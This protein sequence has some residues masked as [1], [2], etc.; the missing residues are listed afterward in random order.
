M[1]GEIAERYDLLNRLLSAGVDQ[2]WRRRTVRLVPPSG[3]GPILDVCTGTGDLALAY[4]RAGRKRIAVVGVDFTRPMLTVGQQ[5]LHQAGASK[6]VR[7]VEGD[8]QQ[9]PFG[10]DTFEIVCAAFGLRNVSDTDQGLREMVRVCRP[11][12]RVAVLEFAMPRMWPLRSLYAWYFRHVLPRIGQALTRN[13]QAAYD[14]L[15]TS[16]GEFPQNEA[17]VE[18]MQSAG[19]DQV[20][21]YRFTLGIAVLYVGVK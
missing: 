4:W 15:P 3:D 5:K 17:L 19:L 14:Y 13:R 9:T 16:V 12:G 18:R 6:L 11:G 10:D 1:F 8:A 7:L 20:C 21:Y 2:Y